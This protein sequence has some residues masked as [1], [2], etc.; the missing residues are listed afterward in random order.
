MMANRD[1]M[2]SKAVRFDMGEDVFVEARRSDVGT[3]WAVR[4]MNSVLN[5]DGEWEYEPMHS[6]RRGDFLART[7]F[8]FDDAWSRA[9][10]AVRNIMAIQGGGDG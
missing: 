9:E 3:R 7:R 5:A 10:S 2:L 1:E 8:G 6:N 4:R